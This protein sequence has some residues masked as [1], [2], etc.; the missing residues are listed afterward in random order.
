MWAAW[1]VAAIALAGAG[2][3]LWFLMAL[4]RECAPSVRYWVAPVRR[5]PEKERHHG[6]LGGIYVREDRSAT[7]AGGGDYRLG[8]AGHENYAK[9]ECC[10]SLIALDVRPVSEGW[11]G[12][13]IYSKRGYVF[14]PHR[15]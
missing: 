10:T 8:L 4:L 3:M 13:S 2:F 1:A 11:G 5:E 12:R 14:P 6:N 15:L 9:E 7:E